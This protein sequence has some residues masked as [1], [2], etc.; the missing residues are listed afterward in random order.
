MDGQLRFSHA[1]DGQIVESLARS[2]GWSTPSRI[3]DGLTGW[4]NGYLAFI[5]EPAGP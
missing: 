4:S 5:R 3:F 1:L 2:A